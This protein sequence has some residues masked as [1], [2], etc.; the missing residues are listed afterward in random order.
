MKLA[1]VLPLVETSPKPAATSPRPPEVR[2][3]SATPSLVIAEQVLGR[4]M[5]V[6]ATRLEH[7]IGVFGL[8]EAHHGVLQGGGGGRAAVARLG[9]VVYVPCELVVELL[10]E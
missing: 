2:A 7:A 4:S 3:A 5:V 1:V 8:E 10:L 9:G 6:P